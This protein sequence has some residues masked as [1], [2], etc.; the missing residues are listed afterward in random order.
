MTGKSAGENDLV[1]RPGQ[2]RPGQAKPSQARPTR[3]IP[4]LAMLHGTFISMSL[5]FFY[6]LLF[7]LPFGNLNL[8]GHKG[9]KKEKEKSGDSANSPSDA[10][11]I[12]SIPSPTGLCK[13]PMFSSP[14]ARG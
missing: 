7:A 4:S 1:L 14:K 8:D 2:A 11:M 3:N 5:L 9:K 6:F 13:L 12:Q 10:T